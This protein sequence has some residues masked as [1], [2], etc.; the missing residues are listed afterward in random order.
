MFPRNP[1]KPPKVKKVGIELAEQLGNK[2]RRSLRK[3]PTDCRAFVFP[4]VKL[5]IAKLEAED[6][7]ASAVPAAEEVASGEF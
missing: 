2:I 5:A 3:V 4:L 6:A 1:N 7:A